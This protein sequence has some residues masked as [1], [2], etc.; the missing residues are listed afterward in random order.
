MKKILSIA[1][2][3]L[4]LAAIFAPAVSA[5]TSEEASLWDL[6]GLLNDSEYSEVASALTNVSNKYNIDVAIVT[7]DSYSELIEYNYEQTVYTVDDAAEV[8]CK[9]TLE[10]DSALLLISMNDRKWCIAANNRGHDALTA[11]GR[12]YIGNSIK[13]YL[14]DKNYK[15]AFLNYVSYIDDFLAEAEKGT[16]YDTNHKVFEFSFK[17]AGISLLIGAIIGILAVI[18]LKGK[19][20][21]VRL[22]AEAN[23]YL[24]QDSLN[25]RQSYDHFLYTHVSRT[26]RHDNDHDSGGSSSHDS[27]SFGSSSGS[28]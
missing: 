7:T 1:F 20:K 13:P 9:N 15:E 28:F 16:P 4:I 6:A 2:I 18:V 3:V 12:E 11:Y 26:E 8:I 14:T 5:S 10:D 23:D 24:V 17:T 22:K 19:Y 27:G 25:V 21:P